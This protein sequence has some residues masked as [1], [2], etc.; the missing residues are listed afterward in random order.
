METIDL[1]LTKEDYKSYQG[2]YFIKNRS[3]QFIVFCLLGVI[4]FSFIIDTDSSDVSAKIIYLTGYLAVF[5]AAVFYQFYQAR[6]IKS[7]IFTGKLKLSFNNESIICNTSNSELIF[8]W[9]NFKYLDKGKSAYYLVFDNNQVMIV[10]KR[11]LT[12]VA[13]ESLLALIKIKVIGTGM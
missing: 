13:E 2:F 7:E 4:C 11:D 1:E 6:K 12:A 10:P 9:K 3:K 5:W 8:P